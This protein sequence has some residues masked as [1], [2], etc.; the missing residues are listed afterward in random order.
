VGWPVRV[1]AKYLAL[2]AFSFWMALAAAHAEQRVALVIGNAAYQSTA[3]LGNPINDAEDLAAALERVGFT[4]QLE[5][6]LTKR[7][8]ENALA[9]FARL[10]DGADAA[11]FFYAGHGIQYR[12]TNYLMPVDA[13]VEDEVSIN[14]EL[15][16]IDDVVFSLERARGVKL[17][18]LDACRNNPLLDRLLRRT[19]TRDV[20]VSRGL[21]RIDPARGMVIAF[22]TQADQVAADGAGRNS[23][24]TSALVKYIGEPGLEVGALFRRVAIEVDRATNGRQL[25]ELSVSLRG[26]FFLNQGETDVQTWS[27]IRQTEDTKE[28]SDFLQRFP[29]SALVPDARQ[30]LDAIGRAQAA[31]EKADSERAEQERLAREQAARDRE[32]RARVAREQLERERAARET[33]AR[34]QAVLEA[35]AREL[36]ERELRAREQ[37]ERDRL[38]LEQAAREQ[39]AARPTA[40]VSPQVAMLPPPSTSPPAPSGT[41]LVRQ[42]KVELKRVGCLGGPID[43]KWTG[44]ETRSALRKFARFAK[45]QSAPDEPSTDFLDAI[46]RSTTRV[47]PLECSVRQ[48][49]KDG[50]CVAKICPAGHRLDGGGHCVASAKPKPTRQAIQPRAS[51]RRCFNLGGQSFCE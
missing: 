39:Q 19:T 22:A 1:K 12:G 3:P 48:I 6:D 42:I 36:A 47:C 28:L 13:R 32:E 9:R 14:Y 25:P 20:P 50:A 2:F 33:A 34:E 41:V 51:G 44:A 24:F 37:A 40:T 27:R 30:R 7:G 29:A 21:A 4:V 23:P 45:L 49:E 38:A 31:R 16:R 35:A 18:V 5:R 15:L 46:R 10:A 43:E 26:E 11:L 8:M 17:L